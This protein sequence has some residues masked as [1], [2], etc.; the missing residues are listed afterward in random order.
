MYGLS[1]SW[2]PTAFHEKNG[3]LKGW[4]RTVIR[5][6]RA[7]LRCGQL[8]SSLTTEELEALLT[9]QENRWWSVKVQS[10]SSK[11]HFLVTCPL[12]SFT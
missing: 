10:F 11:K 9:E 6:L 2:V 12:L 8:V 7:A 1:D 5:L 3:L 4:R